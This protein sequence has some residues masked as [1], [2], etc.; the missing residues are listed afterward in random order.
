MC[1]TLFAEWRIKYMS[2]RDNIYMATSEL[3]EAIDECNDS[4]IT[5]LTTELMNYIS[6]CQKTTKRLRDYSTDRMVSTYLRGN[7]LVHKLTGAKHVITEE[8]FT[9]EFDVYDFVCVEPHKDGDYNYY[10]E[11]MNCKCHKKRK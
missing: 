6:F 4:D 8:E 5:K 2:I 7:V 10:C 3:L 1:G 9:D 11:D